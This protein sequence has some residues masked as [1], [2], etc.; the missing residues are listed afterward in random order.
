[1][2]N[3][4]TKSAGDV[5][6]VLLPL[7][8]AQLLLPNASIAEVVVYQPPTQIPGA[9][10]WLLGFHDWRKERVPLVVFE[11]LVERASPVIG[12]RAR[13]AICKTLGG[14][15][16]RPYI[17]LLLSAMPRLVRVTEEV[18]VPFDKPEDLGENVKQQ[19]VINGEAAWIPDLHALEWVVQEALS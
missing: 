9:P 6:G 4:A 2:S 17:G 15:P 18:I 14:N 3:N 12:N 1:M 10:S 11:T 19:V 13:I 16:R 8:D 5:R 7:Q